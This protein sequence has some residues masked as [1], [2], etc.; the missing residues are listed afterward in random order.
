MTTQRI[1]KPNKMY[2]LG[3][4]IFDL[5]DLFLAMINPLSAKVLHGIYSIS[6]PVILDDL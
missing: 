6:V 1:V 5:F 3:M 2:L 4:E